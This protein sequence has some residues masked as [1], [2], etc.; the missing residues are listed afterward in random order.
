MMPLLMIV[1]C[2]GLLASEISC[3]RISKNPPQGA[4]PLWHRAKVSG[5][6]PR[7]PE[8][9]KI[10]PVTVDVKRL[11]STDNTKFS[12][13]LPDGESIIVVKVRQEM[14]GGD[15]FVW[16]GQVDGNPYSSVTFSVVDRTVMG[17]F[18]GPKGEV[19]RLRHGNG[20]IHVVEMIDMTRHPVKLD[21]PN[22]GPSVNP[23]TNT[24]GQA[25]NTDAPGA[26]G[27]WPIDVMVAYTQNALTGAGGIS[28]MRNTIQLA[29][30][31]DANE[32]Y[33]QSGI[34]QKLNLVC[35]L[36][37]IP[38]SVYTEKDYPEYDLDDMNNGKIKDTQGNTLETLRENY[39]ADVVV[40]LV[41]RSL[42]AAG[43]SNEYNSFVQ[44]Q[45]DPPYS[46]VVRQYATGIDG[47]FTFTHELGHVMGANHDYGDDTPGNKGQFDTGYN[48]GAVHTRP[49]SSS[50]ISWIGWSPWLTVMS[51]YDPCP[52]CSRV[53]R[54]SSSD[55]NIRWEGDVTGDAT[56]DN[57]RMLNE[58]AST[59]ANFQCHKPPPPECPPAPTNLEVK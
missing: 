10:I 17:S 18:T 23:N 59:V 15:G 29:I 58:T 4:P 2:F 19:Y 53:L 22:I 38:S 21:R 27:L 49:I 6:L 40:L 8:T 37:E 56:H 52:S 12:L 55:P 33:R 32:S 44:N 47:G 54:W 48:H 5:E 26:D 11:E 34:K 50:A 9:V 25:C 30:Y 39:G 31:G 45:S 36:T 13:L 43:Q 16:H 7:S 41:E 42:G 28:N 35:P 57:A 1:L 20:D 3:S 51:N 46:V 14:V 24:S